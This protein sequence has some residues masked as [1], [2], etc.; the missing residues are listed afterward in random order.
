MLLYAVLTNVEDF[1]FGHARKHDRLDAADLALG[2]IQPHQ[3]RE[4]DVGDLPED[5]RAVVIDWD[6]STLTQVQF[7][8]LPLFDEGGS[9]GD[10]VGPLLVDFVRRGLLMLTEVWLSLLWRAESTLA[11]GL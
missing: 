5:I 9:L 1:H 2:N 4:A 7:G 10:A 11:D 6:N 3:L 8:S